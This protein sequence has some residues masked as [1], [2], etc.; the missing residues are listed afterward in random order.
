MEEVPE[1]LVLLLFEETYRWSEADSGGVYY[2]LEELSLGGC[3]LSFT[4]NLYLIL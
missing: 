4:D 3:Q 1:R 2:L